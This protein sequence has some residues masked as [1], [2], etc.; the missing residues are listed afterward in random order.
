MAPSYFIAPL[1]LS[2]S[3]TLPVYAQAATSL[4]I[5]TNGQQSVCN[6]IAKFCPGGFPASPG[7]SSFTA[8]VSE[9]LL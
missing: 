2:L 5:G 7:L 9:T 4:P 6:A 8:C 1:L 3:F